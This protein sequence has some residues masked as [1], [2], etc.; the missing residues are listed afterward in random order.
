M[1]CNTYWNSFVSTSKE[2]QLALLIDGNLYK[3]GSRS[4]E[5]HYWKLFSQTR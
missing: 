3:R 5:N 1:K 4:K 2:K